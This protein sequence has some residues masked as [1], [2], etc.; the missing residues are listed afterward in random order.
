MLSVQLWFM[1]ALPITN[2]SSTACP[3]N[4]R[5][6]HTIPAHIILQLDFGYFKTQVQS[7][8]KM[9]AGNA[10]DFSHL[11]LEF[12]KR[13]QSQQ[14]SHACGWLMERWMDGWMDEA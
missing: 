9:T 4:P 3:C 7:I 8:C 10:T 6:F 5:A 11:C 1:Q 14:L 2:E 12:S 13:N